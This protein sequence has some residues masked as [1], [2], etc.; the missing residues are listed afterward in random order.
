MKLGTIAL[1]RIEWQCRSKCRCRLTEKT[2]VGPRTRRSPRV[3]GPAES[4][5]NDAGIFVAG[6]HNSAF[7]DRGGL[8]RS[9]PTTT[10]HGS[11]GNSRPGPPH[12][13]C[14]GRI[15]TW[16]KGT[17]RPRRQRRLQLTLHPI[18]SSADH[19]RV[20]LRVGK[21]SSTDA[22]DVDQIWST[23]TLFL[24]AGRGF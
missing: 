6:T 12:G 4:M 11:R 17:Q 3:H 10:L 9:R 24:P 20:G 21:K 1:V 22:A 16:R 19:D 2:G 23:E 18:L 8:P 7:T 14:L 15:G 13:D 5:S